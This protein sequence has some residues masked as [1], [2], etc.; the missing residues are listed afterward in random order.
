[1]FDKKF[2]NRGEII[3]EPHEGLP[4]SSHR[5]GFCPRC[6]KQSSF[7]LRDSIPVTLDY[8]V[9]AMSQDGR[10]SYDALDQVSVL[11]CR[12]CKQGIA[13]IEEVWIGDHP[14]RNGLKQ[15]GK[16]NFHGINWWPLTEANL[17]KDI[18]K[19]ISKVFNEATICLSANC[20][21]ASVVMAR[22][23]LE[24]IAFDKGE[25]SKKVLFKKLN[26]LTDK[27]I[28]HPNLSDWANEIRLIGNIGAH[29]DPI[30]EVSTEDAKDLISFVRELI[31]YL[32]ELPAELDRKRSSR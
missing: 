14:K 15:G 7:V 23:T 13:V 8:S 20:P 32:Y 2:G 10:R 12:H 17:S 19:N 24:A 22:R 28:L 27:G 21:R 11:F 30:T 18:P 16:I 3:L 9:H 4:D 6:G 29:F 26:A 1:M 31:R 5:S 25:T